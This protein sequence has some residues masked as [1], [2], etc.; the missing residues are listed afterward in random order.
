MRIFA[1]AGFGRVTGAGGI[2]RLLAQSGIRLEAVSTRT[3][4]SIFDGRETII[5]V[6]AEILADLDC[7]LAG[8]RF[9]H[10]GERRWRGLIRA[11]KIDPIFDHLARGWGSL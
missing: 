5:V 6:D 3:C 10:A 7:H 9:H 2:A 1:S 11:A 4:I 8:G